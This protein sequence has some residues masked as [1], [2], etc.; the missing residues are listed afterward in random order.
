MCFDVYNIDQWCICIMTQQ[1]ADLRAKQLKYHNPQE[2]E[3]ELM[4][5]NGANHLYI[6]EYKNQQTSITQGT[7]LPEKTEKI[8]DNLTHQETQK[9]YQEQLQANPIDARYELVNKPP[10]ARLQ[11]RYVHRWDYVKPVRML[12]SSLPAGWPVQ[13]TL[14]E[15]KLAQ[16]YPVRAG[17]PHE[18]A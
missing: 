6:R 14:D 15:L 2:I 1:I 16:H 5:F 3:E 11:D 8:L 10:V 9:R 7:D 12:M 18:A 17:L 13:V 4:T